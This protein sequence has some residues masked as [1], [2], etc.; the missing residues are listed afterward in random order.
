MLLSNRRQ[1]L[2]YFCLAGME[3]AWFTPILLYALRSYSWNV[4]PIAV[5]GGLFGMLLL[6]MLALDLLNYLQIDSPQYELSVAWLVVLSSLLAVRIWLY[7][8]APLGDFSWFG[9]TIY[10]LV[11]FF[12]G[13]R[14]EFIMVAANIFLWQRATSAINRDM[15]LFQ[16]GFNFRLGIL[17]LIIAAAELNRVGG[18]NLV[19]LLWVYFGLGLIAVT[20]ARIH[21]KAI[22]AQSAGSALTGNRLVLLISAVAVTVGGAGWLLRFYTAQT[23]KTVFHWFDPLW[24][25]VGHIAWFFLQILFKLLEPV[26]YWLENLFSQVDWE[27]LSTLIENT[28]QPEMEQFEETAATVPQWLQI[29]MQYVIAGLLGIIVFGGLLLFLR[30]IRPTSTEKL[31]KE[32]IETITQEGNILERGAQLLRDVAGLVQ[33]Y[34]ISRQLLAAISVQ[35]IY[36]NVCRLA[37]QRGYERPR[38]MPPD[39]YLPILI[40]A[41]GSEMREALS[42]IT[43]V[44]MRVHYGDEMVNSTEMAQLQI[45]YHKVRFSKP[46]ET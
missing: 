3:I 6:W 32:D 44:Y 2:I 17:I 41:F 19:F 36:A 7:R 45:D 10:A 11:N 23:F 34:G 43:R 31:A 21:D 18:G 37:A 22:G 30:K 39:S 28:P 9:N 46:R 25:V 29:N 40:E 15:G 16:V 38:A 35:N 4:M 14:P 33:R 5:F 8:A 20:L 27:L 26:I 12:N 13:F 1:G 42:R 24:L